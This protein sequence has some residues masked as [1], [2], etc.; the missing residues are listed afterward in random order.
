MDDGPADDELVRRIA[1]GGEAGR[2]AEAVLCR[3]FAPRVRL[4]GLRHLRDHDRAGELVQ[5][6][7]L[8]V[9]QAARAGR[10]DDPTR[11]DRYVLG[12]S[13]YLAVRLRDGDR[14][15]EPR[16]ELDELIGAA[17]PAVELS[18][19]VR[20]LGHLDDRA[21]QVLVLTFHDDRSAD[22]IASVLAITAGNVRV[23]RHR[24]LASLRHCLDGGAA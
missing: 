19:L 17:P 4:Y 22:E 23:V 13:R 8:A 7:L 18:S 3:R 11:L 16:A 14:K 15:A 1:G 20:C 12:T 21:K 9:L 6:V 10:I 2:T 24:A 5:A